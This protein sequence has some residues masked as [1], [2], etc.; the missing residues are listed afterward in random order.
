MSD[1]ILAREPRPSIPREQ[2][3]CRSCYGVGFVLL[4]AEYD[5]ATGALTQEAT[6][7]PVCKG[8]GSVS[9]YLYGPRH[10]R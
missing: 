2:R 5:A 4:D 3:E 10:G 8:S 6:T 9:V 7:C 1:R